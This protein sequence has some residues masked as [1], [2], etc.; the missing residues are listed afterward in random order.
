MSIDLPTGSRPARVAFYNDPKVR[1]LA[2]QV[3]LCAVIVFL[4]YGAA[5]NAITNLQRANIA[6][7]FGFWY[8]TAGFDISQSLIEYSAQSSTYGRA[9]WVGLLNTLLVGGLGLAPGAN[10]GEGIALFEPTHGSAPKYAGMNK[11]NPTA[12]ILSAVLM[13]RYLGED[14]GA[15]ALEKAV[16]SVVSEGRFTT[17]DMKAERNDPTAVGTR[18]MADAIIARLKQR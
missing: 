12:I 17:Y 18:E 15:D 9:F 1:S 14:T 5:S 11:V 6:S 3:A 2:Y 8:T 7:G 10:I 16:S 4:I 13:L